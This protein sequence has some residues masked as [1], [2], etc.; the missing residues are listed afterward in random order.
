MSNNNLESFDFH[1][2]HLK[3][4]QS[5]VI[6]PLTLFIRKSTQVIPMSHGHMN[7]L[8]GLK[9]LVCNATCSPFPHLYR[10][11][12]SFLSGATV[13][14]AS[15]ALPHFGKLNLFDRTIDAA[16]IHKNVKYIAEVIATILYQNDVP[17]I[18]RDELALSPLYINSTLETISRFSRA[19]P[20]INVANEQ[21]PLISFIE[22]VRHH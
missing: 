11:I 7:S 17:D 6:F 9:F 21:T 18:F 5:A 16:S 14:S 2:R 3:L 10:L 15:E 8:P 1:Y 22:K 13:S 19:S 20:Y 12:S 4:W